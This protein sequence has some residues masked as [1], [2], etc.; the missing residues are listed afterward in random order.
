[1]VLSM[2]N[3]IALSFTCPKCKHVEGI[4][5]SRLDKITEWPCEHCRELTDL[6]KEPYASEIAQKRDN[7]SES[8]KQQRQAGKTIEHWD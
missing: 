7:A 1:M 5:I 8:D 6:S 2:F 3:Q 4:V